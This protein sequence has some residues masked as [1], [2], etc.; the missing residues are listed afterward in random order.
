MIPLSTGVCLVAKEICCESAQ[1]CGNLCPV[2]LNLLLCVVVCANVYLTQTNTSLLYSCS[3]IYD[4]IIKKYC[5]YT[6]VD[7]ELLDIFKKNDVSNLTGILSEPGD[8][9]EARVT[10]SNR[11]VVK[12]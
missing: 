8:K 1:S 3:L 9:L 12:I 4:I 5:I 7:N 2:A 10:D 6:E 11:K